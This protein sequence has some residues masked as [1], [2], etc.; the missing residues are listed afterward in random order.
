MRQMCEFLSFKAARVHWRGALPS[1][2]GVLAAVLSGIH[3][4]YLLATNPL[5]T[6]VST[7]PAWLG[8]VGDAI[9]QLGYAMFA[10]AIFRGTFNIFGIQGRLRL[11]AIAA[12]VLA[13]GVATTNLYAL[14][15]L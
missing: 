6:W 9:A 12:V 1:T 4:W 7:Q 11:L 8:G 14:L 13:L 5:P 2:L 3:R 10:A 15:G